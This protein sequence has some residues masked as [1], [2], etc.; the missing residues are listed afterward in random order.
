MFASPTKK[1]FSFCPQFC[2]EKNRMCHCVTFGFFEKKTSDHIWTMIYF[3]GLR[4]KYLK[5]MGLNTTKNTNA[6]L[7]K[8]RNFLNAQRTKLIFSRLF[9]HFRSVAPAQ[10]KTKQQN[11]WKT[12]VCHVKHSWKLQWWVVVLMHGIF[13]SPLTLTQK[14]IIDQGHGEGLD[15]QEIVQLSTNIRVTCQ[16]HPLD[17]PSRWLAPVDWP[18]TSR[19]L[20]KNILLTGQKHLADWP[21]TW[22]KCKER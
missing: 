12:K 8:A 2:W 3:L 15:Q 7:T 13:N 1:T 17:R 18:K 16:K 22:C 20:A 6:S 9:F 21:K 11:D 4:N 19:W 14:N 5:V 10:S